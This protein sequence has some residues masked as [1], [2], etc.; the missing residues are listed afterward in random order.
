MNWACLV[1]EIGGSSGV[2]KNR[3]NRTNRLSR[4]K[5]LVRSVRVELKILKIKHYRLL[6]GLEKNLGW[7]IELADNIDKIMCN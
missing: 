7:E 4:P 1:I 6:S 5:P 2:R 3:R